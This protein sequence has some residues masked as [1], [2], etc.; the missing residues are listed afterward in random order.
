MSE[1]MKRGP[2]PWQVERFAVQ[3]TGNKTPAR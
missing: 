1:V 3:A 2:E